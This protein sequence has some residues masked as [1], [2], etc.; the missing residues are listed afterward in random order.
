M[1][2]TDY[3]EIATIMMKRK[4]ITLK[5]I[6]EHIGTSSVYAR[7]VIEGMQQGEKAS[8]YRVKIA[9]YLGIN[10]EKVKFKQEA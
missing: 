6:A 3:S 10:L 2:V 7:Q 1:K 4:R 5:D 9:D 8:E